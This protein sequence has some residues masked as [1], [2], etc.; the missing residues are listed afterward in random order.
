[1]ARS[2]AGDILRVQLVLLACTYMHHL[3]CS[4]QISG[5]IDYD[6]QTHNPVL[7]RYVQ[8]SR[9]WHAEK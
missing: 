6:S 5:V 4:T 9:L 1:M 3:R 2:E 8:F 7:F